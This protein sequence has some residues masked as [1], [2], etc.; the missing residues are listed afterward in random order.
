MSEDTQHLTDYEQ[1]PASDEWRDGS[2]LP[3]EATPEEVAQRARDADRRA[4]EEVIED[5]LDSH[6]QDIA[7]C[8]CGQWTPYGTTGTTFRWHVARDV[9]AHLTALT[10]LSAALIRKTNQP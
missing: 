6:R 5:R 9:V 7:T 10:D 2:Y 3:I 1:G 8:S 4:I